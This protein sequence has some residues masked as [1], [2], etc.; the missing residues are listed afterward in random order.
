M[1]KTVKAAPAAQ[2]T[3]A[4]PAKSPLDGVRGFA[5]RAI[6]AGI[7]TSG[8]LDL[9]MICAA[10]PVACAGVFTQNQVAAAP[11]L[12]DRAALKTTRGRA[13]AVLVNAGIANACTGAQGMKNARACA[14]QVAKGLG[15]RPEEVMVCSTGVIGHQLDA[16]KMQAGIARLLAGEGG[17]GAAFTQA[18]MTTDTREKTAAVT[19]KNGARIAG[20]C[21]GSGMIA[22]NMATMLA[23]ILTDAAIAPAAL[24]KALKAAVKDSFNIVSVDGDTSTNDTLLAFASGE[25]GNPTISGGAAYDDF[26][27]GLFKVCRALA[28][29]VAA[30]GEGASKMIRIRLT[31][32][33]TEAAARAAVRAVAQS[34]LVKCAIFGNDPNW[35][36][37]IC[38]VG[39]SGAPMTPEKTT[40]ALCGQTVF[41]KGA[42]QKFDAAALSK[43]MKAKE[44]AIAIDLGL[45]KAA[46]DFL[47]CDFTYDYVKINADYHT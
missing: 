23:F 17:A 31:G 8:N 44:V 45:G 40:I 12:L 18:I 32:A 2:K 6:R 24:Q 35:G 30:D 38:A 15:C 1:A 21:K 28:E 46:A 42:P 29:Q 14:A 5:I 11:V 34:P 26:A 4:K 10:R 27:A 16:K 33:K 25:A 43:K 22:P 9:G 39:Y 20:V 7:K 47:T 19:L 37:I 13:R 36:R 41:K 3:S